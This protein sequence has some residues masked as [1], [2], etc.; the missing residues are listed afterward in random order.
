MYFRR[1]A[2]A[3]AMVVASVC[4]QTAFTAS[5]AAATASGCTYTSAINLPVYGSIPTSYFCFTVYGSGSNISSMRAS[6]RG[7]KMCRWRIDWITYYESG[8]QH[9]RSTGPTSS[10]CNYVTGERY[11]GAGWAPMWGRVCA[12][13]YNYGTWVGGV[14]HRIQP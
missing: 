2:V 13:V 5:P 7:A 14:C 1:V 4:G 10:G 3:F 11:R 8:A 6:W 9:W 12:R